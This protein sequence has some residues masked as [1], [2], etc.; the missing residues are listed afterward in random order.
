VK[1]DIERDFK[2]ARHHKAELLGEL[3]KLLGRMHDAGFLHGGNLF[4][5][6]SVVAAA[7][8]G[9]VCIGYWT[10]GDV[11]DAVEVAGGDE[12]TDE[13]AETV[14]GIVDE[15]MGSEVGVNIDVVAEVAK[16]LVDKKKAL[17]RN[18]SKRNKKKGK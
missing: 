11:H 14:L 6:Q 4:T 17:A 13:E 7:C 18:K 9:F 12:L 10:V 3:H 16:R 5:L 8:D 15:E 2:A 1:K